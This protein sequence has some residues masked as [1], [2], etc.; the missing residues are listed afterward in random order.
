MALPIKTQAGYLVKNIREE[1]PEEEETKEIVKDVKVVVKSVDNP[2]EKPKS[3]VEQ[4]KEK[5][6]MFNKTKEKVAYFSREIIE[7]PQREV[8]VFS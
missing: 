1:D 7:N 3:F 2:I 8:K 6:D 5:Q 4:L